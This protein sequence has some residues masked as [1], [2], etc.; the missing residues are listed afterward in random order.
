MNRKIEELP[1][2]L[3]EINDRSQKDRQLHVSLHTPETGE[4]TA[5]WLLQERSAPAG[6]KYHWFLIVV[7][8]KRS[9]KRPQKHFKFEMLFGLSCL[10]I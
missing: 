3:S 6:F 1:L 8:Y 2:S 7:S 4:N 9:L 10:R 5:V